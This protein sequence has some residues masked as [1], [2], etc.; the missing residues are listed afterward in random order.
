M[1]KRGQHGCLRDVSQPDN[2]VTNFLLHGVPSFVS[3]NEFRAGMAGVCI[4]LYH[5]RQLILAP[6]AKSLSL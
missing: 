1:F 2:S 6:R 3:L 5:A 4:D